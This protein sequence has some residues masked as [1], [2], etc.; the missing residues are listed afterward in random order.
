MAYQKWTILLWTFVPYYNSTT[1]CRNIK[2]YHTRQIS[3]LIWFI[4]LWIFVPYYHLTNFSLRIMPY[5]AGKYFRHLLHQVIIRHINTFTSSTFC[6][7]IMRHTFLGTHCLLQ[8]GRTKSRPPP[9]SAQ[10]FPQVNF[11]EDKRAQYFVSFLINQK[12]AQY[13]PKW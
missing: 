12:N 13:I 8:L 11:G 9:R 6:V 10:Y 4:R 5:H 2:P 1:L 7:A 3:T